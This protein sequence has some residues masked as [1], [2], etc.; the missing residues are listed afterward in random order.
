MIFISEA[1]NFP[2]IVKMSSNE[3]KMKKKSVF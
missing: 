1:E 2:L 3:K